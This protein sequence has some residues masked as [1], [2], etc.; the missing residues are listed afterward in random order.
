M[1]LSDLLEFLEF[2]FFNVLTCNLYYWYFQL[3]LSTVLLVVFTTKINVIL[4]NKDLKIDQYRNIED[5]ITKLG[6]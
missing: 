1:L 3:V 5:L 4:F 6:T 2:L